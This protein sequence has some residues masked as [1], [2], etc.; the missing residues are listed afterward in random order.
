M[1]HPVKKVVASQPENEPLDFDFF[2]L[3]IFINTVAFW[4]PHMACGILVP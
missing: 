3:S 4:P 2:F 1:Q